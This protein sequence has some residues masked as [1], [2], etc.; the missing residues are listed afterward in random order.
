MKRKTIFRIKKD[1]SN[2]Y[3]M[4]DKRPLENPSLSWKAKGLLAYLLSRPDDWE[5][6]IEDL[7]RR[8]TDGD[9]SVRAALKELVL[10]RHLH[11]E[12]RQREKGQ[13][14]RAVW[15]LHEIPL[16]PDSENRGQVQPDGVFPNQE[17]PNQENQA[18]TNIDDTKK[19]P[20]KSRIAH[21]LGIANRIA[22]GLPITGEWEYSETEIKCA[23]EKNFPFKVSWSRA[24]PKGGGFIPQDFLDMVREEGITPSLIQQTAEVWKTDRRFNWQIATLEKVWEKWP[25][26]KEAINDLEPKQENRAVVK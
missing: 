8:S 16:P 5:I 11:Y 3:V 12:G 19:E 24:R 20:T 9:S 25:A 22:V 17:K 18:L 7:I 6:W 13:V 21:P 23:I 1:K 2:P 14:K 4:M 26:L 10:A 15:E